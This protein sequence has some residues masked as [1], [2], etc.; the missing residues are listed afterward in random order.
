VADKTA[1]TAE[2][3]AGIYNSML[4][5][6]TLAGIQYYSATRSAMRV[7]YET[8]SVID[9]PSTKRRI[10]DPV[11]SR[12]PVHLTVYARQKDLTFGDNIYQ[13]DFHSGRGALIFNQRN[14]TSFYYGIIPV[15]GKEKLRSTVAIFD[16]G[17]Y[18]LVYIASMAKAASV[19]GMKDRVG[20]SFANR[21][22]ALSKWFTDQ[23]DKAYRTAHL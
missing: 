15:I 7:F 18:I 9:G 5:L 21:A 8:S 14:L 1:W 23:A 3:E 13:Y 2:E 11:H 10:P 4:A 12:P 16:T 6:S 22:E 20:S 17:N 19:P